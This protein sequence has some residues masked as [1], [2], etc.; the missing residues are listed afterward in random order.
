MLSLQFNSTKRG[1][2]LDPEVLSN[3]YLDFEN[4]KDYKNAVFIQ[5][6]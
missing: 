5:N 2:M 1:I 3:L 4:S 6:F